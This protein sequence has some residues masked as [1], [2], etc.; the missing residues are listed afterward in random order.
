MKPLFKQLSDENQQKVKCTKYSDLYLSLQCKCYTHNLTIKDM[1]QLSD[2]LGVD[3]GILAVSK[4][5]KP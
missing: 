4:L 1:M 2:A 3:F 5:F